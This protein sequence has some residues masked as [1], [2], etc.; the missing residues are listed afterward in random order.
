MRYE[1][2]GYEREDILTFVDE[3][4][5]EIA[6]IDDIIAYAEERLYEHRAEQKALQK[7]RDALMNA[8]G[9]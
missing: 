6:V 3:V 5:E 8:L 9:N 2:E 1:N 4:N 7:K